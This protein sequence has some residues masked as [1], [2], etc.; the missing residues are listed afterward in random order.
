[1]AGDGLY[2]AARDLLMQ[3]GPRVGGQALKGA[4]ESM[5]AAGIRIAPHLDV[6]VFPVQGPPGA[7]KTHIGARMI[8]TLVQLGKRIGITANS[9][10]AI[11][12]ILDEVIEA[13]REQGIAIQ[14]IQKV[15]EK[16]PNLPA[17]QF[18]TDNAALLTAIATT[19]QV[20]AGT[21][22]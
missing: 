10:K 12:N 19:C 5:L 22:W 2:Q 11:R 13:A 15:P 18:A 3:V 7:G 8:C 16:E 6:S 9:H 17:L 21:A 20:A 4:D 1:M 14:C